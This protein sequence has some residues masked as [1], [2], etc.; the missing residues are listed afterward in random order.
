MN[1]TKLRGTTISTKGNF[2]KVGD[3]LPTIHL[4]KSDLSELTNKES[5]F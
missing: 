2:P 4:I 5:S 1:Q 3:Q